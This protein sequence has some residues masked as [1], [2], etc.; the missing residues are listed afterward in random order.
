MA[1]HLG[2]LQTE[3]EQLKALLVSA[4]LENKALQSE[5]GEL[6]AVL[7]RVQQEHEA[8]VIRLAA[9]IL[10]LKRQLFGPKAERIR[11]ADAQQS[12]LD[13]LVELGRLQ[14]GDVAAGDR[15]EA[16]LGELREEAAAPA[17]SEPTT[18]R[19]PGKKKRKVTPHGRQKLEESN[20]P[21]EKIVFE[22]FERK[23]PGGEELV[24][25]GEEV[26]GVSSS[27]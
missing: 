3:N 8:V 11:N 4:R 24:R 17:S 14:K 18:E 7:G 20:L 16:K 1:E 12:F 2:A 25:V 22:P 5:N 23:L 27:V 10:A 9:E 15:A 19:L 13:I 21:V 6:R 26:G